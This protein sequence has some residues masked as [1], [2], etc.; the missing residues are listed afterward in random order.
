MTRD[1]ELNKPTYFFKAK[2][3][4]QDWVSLA[5]HHMFTFDPDLPL[6]ATNQI[7]IATEK[8]GNNKLD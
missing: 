4:L 1:S 8:N 5:R 2:L 7:E 3:M 6:K